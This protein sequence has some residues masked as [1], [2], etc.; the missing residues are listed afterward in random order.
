MP[1]DVAWTPPARRSELLI[2]PIG[3]EGQH[4][5]KD[6]QTGAYFN[7]DA[8]EAFL[9]LQ[10]DGTQTAGNIC[11]T[12]QTRFGDAISTEDVE[13]FVDMVRGQGFIATDAAPA[14]PALKPLTP[15]R[16]AKK[17]LFF[18]RNIFNPDRFFTW[19]APKIAWLW[20]A[21]FFWSSLALVA[22]AGF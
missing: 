10:L 5:V 12:F 14:V 7:L 19:L 6:P 8:P 18:R 15:M 3:D 20:T 11:T 22:V 1:V 2:K 13:Q 9:L 21:T 4:V 16:L 17:I